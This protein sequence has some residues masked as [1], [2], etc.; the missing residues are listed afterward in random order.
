MSSVDFFI[1][2]RRAFFRVRLYVCL[3][4]VCGSASAQT[5]TITVQS[6][7]VLVPTLVRDSKGGVLYGL[8][9]NQFV[10][11][12]N[13][14]VQK[15]HVEDAAETSALSLVVLV[16]CSRSAD[17]QSE[18]L[19][20][21][22][23]MVEALSGQAEQETAVVS[24]GTEPELL[25]GFTRDPD[26][27]YSLVKRYRPCGDDAGASIFDAVDYAARLLETRDPQR[28]RAIL[29]ISET[30][31]HGSEIKPQAVIAKLGKSNIVVDAVS[32]SPGKTEVI[33]DLKHSDGASGGLV[34]LILM[35]VQAVRTNAPKEFARLSGGE[36]INFTTEKGF[37]RSL[38]GLANHVHNGY[39]LSFQPH[40][41]T[42][43][44]LHKITVEVPDYKDSVRHR[45]SYW[46]GDVPAAAVP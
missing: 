31:D 17:E 20:G 39:L 6:N 35:A 24:F 40:G 21:L 30:R 9:A 28:R 19:Q 14:I 26:Q 16:Q 15:I 18:N 44:G 43:P 7:L 25:G 45:E 3:V 37:D 13:G 27:A 38:G 1:A 34:G 5:S 33:E 22:P 23:A 42:T 12:D 41:D 10:V 4:V 29:L 8:K 46:Y 36:Y 11:K 32:F 2:S